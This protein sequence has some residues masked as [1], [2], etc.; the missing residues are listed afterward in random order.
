MRALLCG[1]RR[2]A[3]WVGPARDALPGQRRLRAAR[4]AAGLGRHPPLRGTAADLRARARRRATAASFPQA[5][6]GL[7]ANCAEAGV[8]GV[9]PGVLGTLQ[10][11]EA[12]KLITGVG[13]TA[14]RA[15]PHLRRARHALQRAPHRAAPRL[16]R[17]AATHPTITRTEG[18]SRPCPATASPGVRRL[19]AADLNE[20]LHAGRAAAARRRARGRGICSRPPAR[21]RPHPLGELPQRLGADPARRA[22]P[23]FICRSGGRSLNG[24]RSPCA[25]TSPHPQTS[26]ADCWP[27]RARID[28]ALTV[29]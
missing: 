16:S 15:A 10:A 21:A 11:T 20:L 24:C 29:I 4:P 26:R 2:G 8:L 5:P 6:D 13:T 27:G 22:A 17:C 9:L 23:V 19:S 7:V 14:R 25:P 18:R 12:L 3:R 28:P 1:L